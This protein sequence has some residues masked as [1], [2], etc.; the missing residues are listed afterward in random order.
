MRCSPHWASCSRKSAWSSFASEPVKPTMMPEFLQTA[1]EAAASA[2]TVVEDAAKAGAA[3]H[4]TAAEAV[5]ALDAALNGLDATSAWELARW[6]R[7]Y[8]STAAI[9]AVADA[10]RPANL[11][12][13]EWQQSDARAAAA[14]AHV[15]L[16]LQAA[17]ADSPRGMVAR[18]PGNKRGGKGGC[19][20]RGDTLRDVL[21]EVTGGDG[22]ALA[23][24]AA[25]LGRY[26]LEKRDDPAAQDAA[27][28]AV[29]SLL[30]RL[31]ALAAPPPAAGG[32]WRAAH[33]AA[34][35][36]CVRLLDA[37]AV[38]A[39]KQGAEK[40]LLCALDD[41]AAPPLA[42]ALRAGAH[43][44]VR[45]LCTTGRAAGIAVAAQAEA[46][47][48]DVS[49]VHV[50]LAADESSAE[51]ITDLLA[52]GA[53]PLRPNDF[54]ETPLHVAALRGNAAVVNA[55]LSHLAASGD[56][57]A[58]VSALL[59]ADALGRTPLHA[60][61][62][63]AGASAY[64]AEAAAAASNAERQLETARS[65][66][67][68]GSDVLASAAE[69]VRVMRHLADKYGAEAVPEGAKAAAEEALAALL[70]VPGG[71]DAL[72]APDCAGRL[73]L[74]VASIGPLRE[75][76]CVAFAA[77]LNACLAAASS[78]QRIFFDDVPAEPH[79]DDPFR[80]AV[81]RCAVHALARVPGEAQLLRA[82]L[83]AGAVA[84]ACASDGALALHVATG[85]DATALLLAAHPA[86][87]NA[88]DEQGRSPLF[89]RAAADDAEAVEVLL[90]APGVLATGGAARAHDGHTPLEV[91]GLRAA[92]LLRAYAEARRARGDAMQAAARQRR[93]AISGGADADAA[94]AMLDEDAVLLDAVPV[95][96]GADADAQAQLAWTHEADR[97][98]A[99]LEQ[100]LSA[101]HAAAD[102]DA[103]AL[104][105]VAPPDAPP[106][107]ETAAFAPVDVADE[108]AQL[109]GLTWEVQCTPEVRTA[110]AAQQPD[111]RRRT[112]RC[113][114]DL[115]NGDW[116]AAEFL[117][118][119]GG[120][121]YKVPVS[122]Y[123]ASR[124][125]LLYQAAVDYSPRAGGYVECVRLW[126]LVEHDAFNR[127]LAATQA[128]LRRGG[129]AAVR[130][131]LRI[132]G[133]YR[134]LLPGAC[135]MPRTF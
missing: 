42:T 66:G 20:F 30:R 105:A 44:T 79:A 55:I 86:G 125:R 45:W 132:S 71:V 129:R 21:N 135:V 16:E 60:A 65:K 99:E 33:A 54:H 108:L 62:A 72:R 92:P 117:S 23:H 48:P 13:D 101:M 25:P 80:S 113:L 116:H 28:S 11:T 87:L 97:L 5:Y 84:D 103:D 47:A 22:A 76:P 41:A 134:A 46:A 82:A 78:A 1:L 96:A 61:L 73:P 107:A 52:T 115:A 74:H 106:P 9:L 6:A 2:K 34:A 24:V 58:A 131:H 50:M 91:A 83:A 102:T 37:L 39:R 10:A 40:A 121:L 31:S 109:E 7:L 43:D 130:V 14:L 35:A 56:A 12:E 94:K 49:A 15:G 27:Q 70:A 81:A 53:A 98:R 17:A 75:P 4:D 69:H 120:L 93:A 19:L 122:Y 112:L 95:V 85:R 32:V 29:A 36:G 67:N 110:I 119:D 88:P 59:A 133:E 111:L 51:L 128:S 90:A 63:A 114:R 3:A 124:L 68:K 127:T 126:A 89:A 57:S 18:L 123:C 118:S 26:L 38:L 77:A 8:P 100:E 64:S 104:A